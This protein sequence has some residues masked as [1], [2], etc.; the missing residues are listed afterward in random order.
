[1]SSEGAQEKDQ[2]E[3]K[4]APLFMPERYKLRKNLLVWQRFSVYGRN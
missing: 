3:K 2:N 1:M 4:N